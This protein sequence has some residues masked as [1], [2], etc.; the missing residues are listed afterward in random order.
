MVVNDSNSK[1]KPSK[2]C[3][4]TYQKE[5]L[6]PQKQLY[7]KVYTIGMQHMTHVTQPCLV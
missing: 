6:H 1:Q 4:K 3:S 5:R 2:M 7:H